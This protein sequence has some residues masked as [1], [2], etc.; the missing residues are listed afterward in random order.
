MSEA[1]RDKLLE[2]S[3]ARYSKTH[4]LSV[5]FSDSAYKFYHWRNYLLISGFVLLLVAKV[6]SAYTCAR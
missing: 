2:S 1:E 3:Q 6:L 4:Q 5:R